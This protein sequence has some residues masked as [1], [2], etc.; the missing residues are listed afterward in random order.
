MNGFGSMVEP[1][2]VGQLC[3]THRPCRRFMMNLVVR[4]GCFMYTHRDEERSPAIMEG[5]EEGRKRKEKKRKGKEKGED[6]DDGDDDDYD[7]THTCS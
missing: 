5:R 7:L 2:Q 4:R 3:D 1:L 6:D